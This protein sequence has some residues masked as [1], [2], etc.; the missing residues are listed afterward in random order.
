MVYDAG[1]WNG[2]RRRN[3]VQ[4]LVGNHEIELLVLFHSDADHLGDARRILRRHR[5][6]Q[7]GTPVTCGRRTQGRRGAHPPVL[8]REANP[9]GPDRGR[10]ADNS[11]TAV[12]DLSPK[13]LRE[14]SRVHVNPKNIQGH[15]KAPPGAYMK[16]ELERPHRSAS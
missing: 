9:P 13:T 16:D 15:G 6:R 5:V 3:A 7:T 8:E 14:P 2:R 10:R 11:E 12:G 4:K 1:H